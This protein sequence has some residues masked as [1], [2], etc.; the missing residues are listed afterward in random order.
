MSSGA[1]V[2]SFA[3]WIILKIV[4][5]LPFSAPL[6]MMKIALIIS[7]IITIFQTRGGGQKGL[8][9]WGT[10]FFFAFTFVT[11]VLM[12]NMWGIIHLG[13]LANAK[14]SLM[15]WGSILLKKPFTMAYAK[16]RIDPQYW[17]HPRFIRKNIYKLMN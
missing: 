1:L 15:T 3:P 9:L 5:G 6:T 17:N 10:L 14:L 7:I 4:S 12:S 11:I 16:E 2:V 13:V 8:M